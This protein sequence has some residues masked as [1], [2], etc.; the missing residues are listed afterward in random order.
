MNSVLNLQEFSSNTDYC[1]A[2]NPSQEQSSDFHGDFVNNNKFGRKIIIHHYNKN[3]SRASTSY[4]N[5]WDSK[6]YDRDRINIQSRET[7]KN[8]LK[9]YLPFYEQH[10]FNKDYLMFYF[11]KTIQEVLSISPEKLNVELTYDLSIFYSIFKNGHKAYLEFFLVDEEDTENAML[12]ITTYDGESKSFSGTITSI[13][14]KLT[15][16]FK[17]P[18]QTRFFYYK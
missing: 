4:F 8:Q 17:S 16:E 9:H 15:K 5:L 14:E 11:N 18:S 12:T 13:L 6:E 7:F 3:R 10:D 1:Y 2:L